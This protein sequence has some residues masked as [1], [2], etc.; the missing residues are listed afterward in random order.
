ME[1][2]PGPVRFLDPS[3]RIPPAVTAFLPAAWYWVDEPLR[4]ELQTSIAA[5]MRRDPTLLSSLRSSARAFRAPTHDEFR[6]PLELAGLLLSI[7]A[8]SDAPLRDEVELMVQGYSDRHPGFGAAFVAMIGG[9]EDDDLMV[10]PF[11]RGPEARSALA[12][13]LGRFQS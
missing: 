3:L 6:P 10:F 2:K 1:R 4:A 12:A 5:M 9:A 8:L 7:W 11:G 13:L